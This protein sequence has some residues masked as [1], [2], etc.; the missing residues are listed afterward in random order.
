MKGIELEEFNEIIE[1][2]KTK[3]ERIIHRIDSLDKNKI[4]E[5]LKELTNFTGEKVKIEEYLDS[6]FSLFH[7]TLNNFELNMIFK[8]KPNRYNEDLFEINEETKKFLENNLPKARG[9]MIFSHELNEYNGFYGYFSDQKHQAGSILIDNKGFIIFV[10]HFNPNDFGKEPDYYLPLYEITEN[11]INTLAYVEE[12][13]NFIEYDEKI[14]LSLEIKGLENWIYY[15][16][17]GREK[18]QIFQQYPAKEIQKKYHS[19][20]L[21]N[22]DEKIVLEIIGPIINSYGRERNEILSKYHRIK[23]ETNS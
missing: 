22:Q 5:R 17:G 9:L 6:L 15:Y 7:D 4:R 10:F 23:T 18:P 13:Y 12:F 8:I 14:S 11:F 20:E 3:I 21:R 2:I 16:G 19:L 1:E